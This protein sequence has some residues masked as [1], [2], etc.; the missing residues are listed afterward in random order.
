MEAASGAA[1]AADQALRHLDEAL[2]YMSRS[3]SQSPSLETTTGSS[4]LAKAE[5]EAKRA[6]ENAEKAKSLQ[7]SSQA[8]SIAWRL[9]LKTVSTSAQQ[10][11]E[12]DAHIADSLGLQP[13]DVSAARAKAGGVGSALLSLVWESPAAQETPKNAPGKSPKSSYA[14]LLMN[15]LADDI[16]RDLEAAAEWRTGAREQPHPR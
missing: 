11:R 8:H 5:E 3:G 15:V 1:A 4:E 10:Q 6:G 7:V 14:L 16:E 2:S 13:Q 12:V 9:N